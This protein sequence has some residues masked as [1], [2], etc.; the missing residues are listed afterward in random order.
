MTRAAF[1]Y[2][3]PKLSQ[4]LNGISFKNPVGLSAGFD[5]DAN[6]IDIIPDV[7]F[8]F[9][10]IGSVTLHPYEGNPQPRLYR[11][12]KS[13]GLVVYYGLKN[14]GVDKIISKLK[15]QHNSGFPLLISIAKTNSRE[16]CTTEEGIEDYYQ[17][18]KRILE[19][20]IGEIYEINISCPNTFGGE[21]YTTPERL[22]GL[23]ARIYQLKLAKPLFIKMPINLKWGEFRQLLLVAIKHRVDGVI[24]GNLNKDHNSPAVK[25]EIP[26]NIKGGI[27]GKPTWE[28]SNDLISKTYEQFGKDLVIVGVGGIFSAEDAYEKIKRGATLLQ[29]IT[30]MIYQG[31]QLIGEI[32]K[33]LQKLLEK[34]GYTNISEAVGAYHRLR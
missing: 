14:I 23:L 5:K 26:Q 11:L 32:N 21:P 7:G 25:D 8:G 13:K 30:G 16:T 10:S 22:E 19:S 20:G 15:A 18:L 17:C 28:L 1:S 12:I 31:P 2:Q 6:L 29:L 34:D 24:I 33:G 9:M 3:N 4:T 27:S